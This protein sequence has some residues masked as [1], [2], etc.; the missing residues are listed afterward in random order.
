MRPK[1]VCANVSRELKKESW[2]KEEHACNCNDDDDNDHNVY[3]ST[4]KI[5]ET[6]RM[7]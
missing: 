4:I 2:K 3:V 1:K 7:L 6:E 5:P